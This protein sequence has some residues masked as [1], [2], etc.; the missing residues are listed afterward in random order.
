MLTGG[1]NAEYGRIMSGAVNV[2]TREGGDRYFGAI[3]AVSDV[4]SGD[5]VGSVNTDYNIYDGSLGGPLWP[6]ART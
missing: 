5:W 4:L 3:E 6:G 2:I 1:F